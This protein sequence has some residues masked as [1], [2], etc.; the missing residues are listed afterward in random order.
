MPALQIRDFP[1]SL[2]SQ[3]A[4]RA[5]Q[6]RRT[7][8]QQATVLLAQA[9]STASHQERRGAILSKISKRRPVLDF[10]KIPAPEDLIR[11]DRNR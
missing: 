5:K 3:L 4:E 2:H 10:S 9:L 8:A 6:E 11:E 7:I 1:A